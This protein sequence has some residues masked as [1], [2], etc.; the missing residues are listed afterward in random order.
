MH[1]AQAQEA[2]PTTPAETTIIC[3][4]GELVVA[5]GPDGEVTLAVS[6]AAAAC[7]WRGP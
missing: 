4:D 7:S 1:A 5:F 2:G 3:S 6:C